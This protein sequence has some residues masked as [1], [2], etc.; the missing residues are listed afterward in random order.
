MVKQNLEV[1]AV[2]IAYTFRIDRFNPRRLLT[3]FLLN[4]R[5]SLK[6]RNEN[7]QGSLAAV[8]EAKKKHLL[9]L[10]SVI[11]CLK[12]HDIDPSKLLPE[13]KINEKIMALEKEIRGFDKQIGKNAE[14]KRK[15][16]ETESSRGSRNREAKRSYN[17]PWVR[18]QRVDDHVDN[19]NTLP[20][21]R[22]TG[23][24]H[25]YTVSSTV[26]HGP[27]AGLI[28]ENIAG[29]LVGTVGGV[30]MGVPGAGISASG[31]GNHAGISAGTD[32][33]QQGGP[34]AG[35]HGGT[36]VDSTPGQVGSHTDQLYGRSGNAAVND[37]LA[38]CSNAYVPSSYLDGSKG[39]PNTTHTD[40]LPN[41]ISGAAGR[42]SASDI[43]Q[44]ADTDTASELHMSSG[45]RAVDTVSSA[46]SAHPSSN[47]YQP[48]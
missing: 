42:S 39:L 2:H 13:W 15:S 48:K 40:A 23:Q 36:L 24:L 30:A 28:H 5:E 26:L 3:S 33:V 16:D 8:N 11:K 38:S 1:D 43:Y 29:S 10:T 9:D 31:N 18:Q 6:K 12:C 20:E 14:R 41:A 27:S 4:S 45:V 44:V 17:P 32:V 7:S 47:L 22:T 34:Y 21:G 37:S 19:N 35:G 25:G 46:A